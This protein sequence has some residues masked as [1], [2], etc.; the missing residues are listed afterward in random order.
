LEKLEGRSC[1]FSAKGIKQLAALPNLSSMNLSAPLDRGQVLALKEIK[2]LRIIQLQS[3]DPTALD[4]LRAAR[5]DLK[6]VVPP[7][8]KKS[9]K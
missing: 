1:N 2:S 3:M 7:A 5:P 9:K 6:I 8:T 4:E